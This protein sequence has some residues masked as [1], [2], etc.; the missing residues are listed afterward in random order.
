M[1]AA[2]GRGHTSEAPAGASCGPEPPRRAGPPAPSACSAVSGCC[3]L[4]AEANYGAASSRLG[5]RMCLSPGWWPGWGR[6]PARSSA[7]SC[8][9][10]REALGPRAGLQP[11]TLEETAKCV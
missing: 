3:L 9:P 2:A 7:M 10:R 1:S 4:A 8:S 5:L 6:Q 11:R